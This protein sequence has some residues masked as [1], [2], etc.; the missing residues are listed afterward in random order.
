MKKILGIELGSTRIK[1]VLIDENAAVLSSGS[2]EWENKLENG[3]WTYSL[4]DVWTGLKNAYA[5]LVKNFG[6]PIES[7]D[8]IGIS[9]MMHGY[10]AFDKNDKLL[11]PFRTWRNVNALKAG[12]E[13]SSLFNFNVPMR[14][15]V[16]QYYQ[17]V[18]D[19]LE[20]VKDVAFLT[21]LSGYVHYRLTGKKVIGIND[22]SGIFPV[23]NRDY[24]DNMLEKFNAL[25]KEKGYSVNFKDLLPKVLLSGENAGELTEFGAKWLDV[26]GNLKPGVKFCPPE[27]D[28]GTGMIATNTVTPRT[29]NISAGTSVNIT[30]ALERPLKNY[31]PE[32][33]VIATPNGYPAIILH[34]A[35][36]TNEINSWMSVFEEVLDTFGVNVDKG[37]LY[38]KLFNKALESDSEI[39]GLLAYNFLSGEPLAKTKK[40][41][42]LLARGQDGKLNLANF[43]QA[44]IYS[45]I[46]TLAL[47]VEIFD[48]EG[49]EIDS[50]LAHG[51]FYK[52]DFIGQN[53]TSALLNA[54]VT[55]YES[56]S[57]GG[58][59]GIALLALYLDNSDKDL[60]LF[61][62]E[63]FKN[64]KKKVILA[65][66]RE[67]QKFKK[68]VKRYKQN[69]DIE[70]TL[71]EIL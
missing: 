59:Y 25:L 31:Y 57:E 48:N 23:L 69:L 53:A 26:S 17:S 67:K 45:A 49:I 12:K 50:V 64:S 52:T 68:F 24:N 2:H 71:T 63:I 51:G 29:A 43:M 28:M 11:A 20:H 6:S 46:A 41:A 70:R 9:A 39:G 33:D 36:C 32:L 5:D 58:A 30:V 54:P 42:L 37:E 38:N 60:G 8:S 44:Q 21:T 47:G 13:L 3:Y 4:E 1:A 40:G 56:A 55:V 7:L 18:L 22:G 10:L 62:S 35:N 34:S 14:W 65:S 27:G 15:S 66:D 61:L 19:N 16:S